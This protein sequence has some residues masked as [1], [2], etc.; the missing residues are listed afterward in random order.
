MLEKLSNELVFDSE[1]GKSGVTAKDFLQ[2]RIA[3]THKSRF[4]ARINVMDEFSDY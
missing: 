3:T 4:V 1:L 2:F